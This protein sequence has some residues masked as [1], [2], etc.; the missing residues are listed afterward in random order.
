MRDFIA[1]DESELTFYVDG[2][3]R[4][5][6]T[7]LTHPQDLFKQEIEILLTTDVGDV[8]GSDVG[9]PLERMIYSSR[10]SSGNIK[11]R[12]KEGIAKYCGH[13]IKFNWDVEV[14]L[15]NGSTRD[16]AI[17]DVYFSEHGSEGLALL[18]SYLIG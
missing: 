17:V 1:Y 10:M 18:Q 15:N 13:A 16:I 2:G 11:Q 14:T 4:G 3:L 7:V 6:P 5:M 12:V 9:L 8:L